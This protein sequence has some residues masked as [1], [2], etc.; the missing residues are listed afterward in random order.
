MDGAPWHELVQ[1]RHVQMQKNRSRSFGSAY[2]K[3]APL[4]MTRLN[5]LV[6]LIGGADYWRATL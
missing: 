5:F 1:E 3:R 2:P 6:T 4:W